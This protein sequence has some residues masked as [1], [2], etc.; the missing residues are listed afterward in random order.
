MRL[1]KIELYGFKSFAK[2]NTSWMEDEEPVTWEAV[3]ETGR[4]NARKVLELFRRVV[5]RIS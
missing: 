4:Q 1:S 5:P 3:A 2:K